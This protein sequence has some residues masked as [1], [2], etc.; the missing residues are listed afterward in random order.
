MNENERAIIINALDDAL[1][2]AIDKL[3]KFHPCAEFRYEDIGAIDAAMRNAR[4]F[5]AKEALAEKP[6]KTLEDL[7]KSA[8]SK[9]SREE[10]DALGFPPLNSMEYWC[11]NP[12]DAIKAA[13]CLGPIIVESVSRYSDAE[14]RIVMFARKS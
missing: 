11:N 12:V 14:L 13:A 10:R 5:L 6:D 7:R 2:D 8:F 1:D 4:S 9:L 3:G